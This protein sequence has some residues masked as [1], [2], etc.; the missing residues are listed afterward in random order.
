[1][2]K[3]TTRVVEERAPQRRG[4]LPASAESPTVWAEAEAAAATIRRAASSKRFMSC[5]LR[6][7][8]GG[9]ES[10]A[11]SLNLPATVR[12]QG[13]PA[14]ITEAGRTNYR[15]VISEND[16]ELAREDMFTTGV[17]EDHDLIG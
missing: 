7:F 16:R 8:A 13:V 17:R 1:M 10:R 2:V 3:A 11:S 12:T 5:T 6:G 9:L 14:R 4:A 15:I